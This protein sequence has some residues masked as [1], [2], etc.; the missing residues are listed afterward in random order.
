M[1]F[2]AAMTIILAIPTLISSF[3]GMNVAV[4]FAE[5]PE[6]F[7]MISFIAFG[8]AGCDMFGGGTSKYTKILDDMDFEEITPKEFDKADAWDGDLEDG[9]YAIADEKKYIKKLTDSIEFDDFDADD[10]NTVL[11]AQIAEEGEYNMN[12]MAVIVI[13]FK[14]ADDAEDMFD[15]YVDFLEE[16]TEIFEEITEYGGDFE[17]DDDDNY[18]ILD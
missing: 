16:E 10:I 12:R 17:T 2:L 4:P 11:T 7:A 13:S 18:F 9:V 3:F 6:A 1:K 8:I 5:V 14:N 15:D